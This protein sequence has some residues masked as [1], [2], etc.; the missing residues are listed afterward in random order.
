MSDTF[1]WNYMKQNLCPLDIHQAQ[2]AQSPWRA[3]TD[4][5]VCPSTRPVCDG[6]GLI[7]VVGEL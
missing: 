5:D 6:V 7:G 3:T 2:L 4:P 1:L